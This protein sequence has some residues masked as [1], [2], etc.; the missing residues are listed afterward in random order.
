M[1]LISKMQNSNDIDLATVP[2]CGSGPITYAAQPDPTAATLEYVKPPGTGTSLWP[3]T[4]STYPYSL[5]CIQLDPLQ[6]WWAKPTNRD[7]FMH[8]SHTFTHEAQD[9]ATY[10]DVMKEIAWN[11]AWVAQ[12]G[13]NGAKWFSNKGLIPPAITGL[14]NG[15]ALRAWSENGLVN[16]V[17]DN[18]RPVLLNTVSFPALFEGRIR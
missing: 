17:G 12:W 5:A 16:A 2:T 14:H 6:N 7:A 15:D 3:A 18:T 13:L 8:I 9:A 1:Y 11:Q 10:S 4:A